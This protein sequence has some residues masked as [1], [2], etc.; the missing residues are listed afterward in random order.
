MLYSLKIMYNG[1][2]FD[3]LMVEALCLLFLSLMCLLREVRWP[4]NPFG[5]QSVTD[6]S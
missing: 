3:Y 1:A 6:F 5:G 2:W 4:G